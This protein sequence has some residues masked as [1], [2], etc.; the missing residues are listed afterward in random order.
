MVNV[1]GVHDFYSP[2]LIS[3]VIPFFDL[4]Y[5][6][7]FYPGIVIE[8]HP[9]TSN[10]QPLFRAVGKLPDITR[11]GDNFPTNQLS[12]KSLICSLPGFP[13]TAGALA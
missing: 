11:I 10:P 2:L 4:F 13:A 8:N 7:Y 6:N 3:A 1:L 12:L 5:A 9:V